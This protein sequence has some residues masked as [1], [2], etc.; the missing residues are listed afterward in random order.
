MTLRRIFPRNLNGSFLTFPVVLP[1]TLRFVSLPIVF[2][3]PRL[4][5]HIFLV[6][7]SVPALLHPLG[8][9]LFHSWAYQRSLFRRISFA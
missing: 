6:D 8:Y 5:L 9:L 3:P 2:L 7:P 4:V 1:I